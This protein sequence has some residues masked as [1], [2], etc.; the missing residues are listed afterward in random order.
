[1]IPVFALQ[2]LPAHPYPSIFLAGPTPRLPGIASWRPYALGLLGG[3]GFDG[4]VFI[5]E[6]PDWTSRQSYIPQ[7]DWEV[8]ALRLASCICF[9]I[10][11][12]LER[13]PGFNTN[14]EFGLTAASGRVVLGYPKGAPKMYYLDLTARDHGIPVFHDLDATLAAAVEIANRKAPDHA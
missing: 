14:V 3:L 12:D 6:S 8:A 1:M 2:D 10:P 4:H 13:M 11:R 5:P 9:W 7:R